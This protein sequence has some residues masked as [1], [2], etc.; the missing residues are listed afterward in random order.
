MS[1][2]KAGSCLRRRSSC[3]GNVCGTS[4]DLEDVR[5]TAKK[6][7]LVYMDKVFSYNDAT[8]CP[9]V[10][11]INTGGDSAPYYKTTLTLCQNGC[12]CGCGCNCGC[13]AGLDA[14]AQFT[15]EDSYVLV[16]VFQPAA[17]SMLSP[18]Q[19][20]VDGYPVDSV[21][22]MGGQ[23]LAET[24]N[25]IPRIQKDRCLEAGLPTKT[26]FLISNAGP[27]VFRAKF[28]LT[29]TVSTGGQCSN[30]RLEIENAPECPNIAL[31]SDR[32]SNFVINDLSL[33]CTIKG[34]SPAIRFQFGAN[35]QLQNPRL[36]VACEGAGVGTPCE[37]CACNVG[38]T[39]N[40][41]FEPT[42]QTEV[43][44]KTLFCVDACEA[45]IPCQGSLEEQLADED[46]VCPDPYAPDCRCGSGNTG[47]GGVSAGCGCENNCTA[48]GSCGCGGSVGGTA[49][50]GCGCGNSTAGGCGCGGCGCGSCGGNS[51]CG[52]GCGDHCHNPGIQPRT[53][54][55]TYQAIGCN[56]CS[57]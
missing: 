8:G 40:I 10:V 47:V 43:I 6:S 35:A 1:Q 28:V 57:W 55:A 42:V 20:T 29:G 37:T 45:M 9:L 50:T 24:T 54:P 18:C 27:W 19:V 11:P 4:I 41:V 39:A 52:G 51:G 56:G 32:L 22:Q 38:L 30:F 5:F 31:P 44:R 33:P 7:N 23:Y 25:L 17:N 2:N 36:T 14:N 34:M 46:E 13:S 49:T 53:A 15:V 3:L 21:T 26:F 48:G 16:E 12:G